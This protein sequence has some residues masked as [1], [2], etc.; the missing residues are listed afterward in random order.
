MLLKRPALAP[1]SLAMVG[2]AANSLLARGALGGALAD[3]A[4]YTLIRLASGAAL[5]TL[6][7]RARRQP[8][9]GTWVGG[10]TLALYAV[11]FSYSYVRIGA[12]L[13]ALVLFVT[14]KLALL[15]WGYARGERPALVEWLGAGLA[16]AGLV[17]L[18]LPGVR[19]G[20]GIGVALMLVAA[21]AW[22]MYT[23]DGTRSRSPLAATAGNF[24]RSVVIAA[25][26]LFAPSAGQASTSGIVLAVVS[27]AIA[28]GLAY[29]LW[30]RAIPHLTALQLGLAQ[31]AV[32]AIATL[33]AVVI[34]GELLTVRLVLA[35]G[36]IF[37]GLGIAVFRPGGR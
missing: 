35:A 11:A 28:S 6:W 33:G 10:L 8:L 4:T 13:G 9:E 2:F 16:L 3:P 34:L 19:R 15:A 29:S 32:P 21:F 12:A 23:V 17:G 26:L 14:V 20:D 25:P 24:L 7:V 18:T 27:G 31:L 1:T 30:Y 22:A 5:L 36:A 37:A